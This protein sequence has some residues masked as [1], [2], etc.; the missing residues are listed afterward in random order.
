MQRPQ[1]PENEPHRLQALH[2]LGILDTAPEERFDR[3]TRMARRLFQVPIALVSLVDEDRQWFKSACGLDVPETP[4]DVSFCGHAILGEDLF[5]VPDAARDPRFADNPLVCR[6]PYVRFYAGCPLRALSGHRV[7]TLCVIDRQPRSFG[8]DD[9]ETLRDLARMVERELAAV[10]LATMDELTGL[11]NRR[12]FLLLAEYR[13]KFCARHGLS[14]SLAFMDLDGFKA[15][16]DTHGHAE[17]DY[18]LK[19][20]AGQMRRTFRG[21]DVLGRLGGDEFAVLLANAAEETARE[22][23]A[24]FEA[25]LETHNREVHRGYDLTF[26]YGLVDIDPAG[27]PDLDAVLAAGDALM[28]RAKAARKTGHP[29]DAAAA[30]GR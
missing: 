21:S 15:I 2:A 23:V 9:E 3:L 11:S 5:I 20:F 6:S 14:A 27:E 22:A 13:L 24:R 25:D 1:L 28:Y 26:S 17:G 12:G 8:A 7:G 29:D 10:E 19:A 30:P 16:N 18:A 4:R